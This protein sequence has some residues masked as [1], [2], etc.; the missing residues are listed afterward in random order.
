MKFARRSA[1]FLIALAAAVIFSSPVLADV[2]PGED[3]TSTVLSSSGADTLPSLIPDGIADRLGDPADSGFFSNLLDLVTGGFSAQFSKALKFFGGLLCLI[4]AAAVLG[5]IRQSGEI[6]LNAAIFEK[7]AALCLAAYCL[8]PLY[9]LFGSVVERIRGLCAFMVS[10]IPVTG[11]LWAMGGNTG[12]AAA[13]SAGLVLVSDVFAYLTDRIL[14]PLSG[15]LFALSAAAAA[16]D[17][18]LRINRTVKRAFVT[19]LSFLMSVFVFILGFQTSLSKASDTLS[20]R[21]AKFAFSGFIPGVGSLVGESART[22]A[23]AVGYVR[24]VSGTLCA[25]AVVVI[26]CA[27][28]ASVAAFKLALWGGSVF[29][30]L[31]SCPA[32]SAFLDELNELLGLLLGAALCVGVYFLISLSVFVMTGTALGG[33][34]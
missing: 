33:V 8:G 29:A 31:C 5:C 13:Q 22:V 32:M 1:F 23:A 19:G 4:C 16:S 25:A 15:S 34:G 6:T 9:S 17:G 24:S 21:T 2:D 30:S 14:V 7:I 3:L 20:M 12:C 28:I 27:P 11:A 18:A 26:C 10:L